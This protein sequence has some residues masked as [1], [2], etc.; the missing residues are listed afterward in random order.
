[1]NNNFSFGRIG[2]MLKAD[3]IEYKKAYLLFAGLLFAFNLFVFLW[4]RQGFQI[5]LFVLG[6]IA[7]YT[8]FYNYIGWKVH[9]SK[10][11]FLTLP[12][13]SPE[14]FVEMLIVWMLLFAAYLLIYA[15]LMGACHLINGANIWFMHVWPMNG[16][17][18]HFKAVISIIG[19]I[20]FVA[21]FLFMSCIAIRKYPLVLGTIFLLM[22]V[23]CNALFFSLFAY[24]T[25]GEQISI[26]LNAGMFRSNSLIDAVV[27]IVMNL[28]WILSISWLVLLYISYVKLKEKQIR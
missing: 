3:W 14:K 23:F 25:V 28:P 18:F 22:Y 11:R 26:N 5:F 6:I 13:G 21:T 2:L 1:M 8:F 12:A 17:S 24:L 4:S 16:E 27:F 20:L 15:L 19:I 9:R 7:T 10:S